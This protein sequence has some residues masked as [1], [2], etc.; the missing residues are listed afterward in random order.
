LFPAFLRDLQESV[1]GLVGDEELRTP[2][3]MCLAAKCPV[4]ETCTQLPETTPAS[5]YVYSSGFCDLQN[6]LTLQ[7][8]VAWVSSSMARFSAFAIGRK[9]SKTITSYF[10]ATNL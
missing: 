8:S 2:P 5:M 1:Q 4:S 10:A 7:F 3:Q 9:M 6:T